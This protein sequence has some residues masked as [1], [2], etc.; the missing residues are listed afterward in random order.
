MF[1]VFIWLMMLCFMVYLVWSCIVW[2]SLGL[3]M[4]MFMLCRFFMILLLIWWCCWCCCM[5]GVWIFI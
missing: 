5:D 2:C 4:G 1:R 3:I